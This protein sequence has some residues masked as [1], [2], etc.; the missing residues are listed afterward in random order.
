MSNE[1]NKIMRNMGGGFYASIK[2]DCHYSNA[3]LKQSAKTD[4]C[5]KLIS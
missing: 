2:F 1:I 3:W 5:G 4:S